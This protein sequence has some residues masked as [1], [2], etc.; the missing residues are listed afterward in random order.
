MTI[1]LDKTIYT[2]KTSKA[3]IPNRIGKPVKPVRLAE[4]VK[5]KMYATNWVK[6]IHNGQNGKISRVKV[7]KEIVIL[8][9]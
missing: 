5:Y 8:L 2:C 6:Q 1:K 9:N 4:P 7:L 3:G